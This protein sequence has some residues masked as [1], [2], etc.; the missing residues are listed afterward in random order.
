MATVAGDDMSLVAGGFW[1]Q[2]E[3]SHSQWGGGE[4]TSWLLASCVA[5]T[6]WWV[7]GGGPSGC[8]C[9]LWSVAV[10]GRLLRRLCLVSTWFRQKNSMFEYV[11]VTQK[12]F[13]VCSSTQ[14]YFWVT[15]KYVRVYENILE[16][17]EN[18][19]AGT[20]ISRKLPG[21]DFGRFPNPENGSGRDGTEL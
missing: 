9:G 5:M 12:Y 14:K 1:W 2:I 15:W 21:F 4:A 7:V 11:Q 13:Q 10:G 16:L 8:A 3:G 17:P 18:I 6:G 20:R 19:F